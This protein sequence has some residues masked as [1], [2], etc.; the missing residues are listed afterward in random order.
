MAKLVIREGDY[1]H[2]H[3]I[4]E[5]ETLIGRSQKCAVRLTEPAASRNHCTILKTPEG[6]LLMDLQSSNG[7][8]LNGG[9]VTESTLKSGDVIR[10]GNAELMFKDELEDSKKVVDVREKIREITNDQNVVRYDIVKTADGQEE[11]KYT[12]VRKDGGEPET[13]GNVPPRPD[14]A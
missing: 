12:R 1:V 2:E 7:T 5:I 4:E 11:L 14:G 13:Q 8:I 6:F 10:I 9:R 3:P